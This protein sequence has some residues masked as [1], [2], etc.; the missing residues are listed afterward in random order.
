MDNKVNLRSEDFIGKL[1][2]RDGESIAFVVRKYTNQLYRA[3]LGLGFQST[4][5]RELVQSVWATFF[6]VIPN[7]RGQ[8]HIRTFIFGIL[9]N[10]AK[11]LRRDESRLDAPD[12]IEP[13]LDARFDSDGKWIT[14]PIDPEKFLLASETME[15]IQKCLDS[16]PLTQRMAFCLKEIDGERS[17]EI[18]NILSVTVTNLGVLL[19][20]AKNRLRECI[21]GK[22]KVG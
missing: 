22:A 1:K 4:S 3:S 20:R 19:F 12:S 10:K 18:C 7:F 13:I 21:E 17:P 16:L 6:D 11:E 14:P 15:L 2:A 9:Y 5:A 8:A